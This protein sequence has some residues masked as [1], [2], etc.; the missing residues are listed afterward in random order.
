MS[1]P[2]S[3]V[4]CCPYLVDYSNQTQNWEREQPQNDS[5]TPLPHPVINLATALDNFVQNNMWREYE[6][7][8]SS[9]AFEPQP[10]VNYTQQD[11]V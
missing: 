6:H 11:K 5:D 8:S 1:V 7:T 3:R 10:N 4:T 9:A 2:L